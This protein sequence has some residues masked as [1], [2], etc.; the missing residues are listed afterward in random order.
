[1]MILITVGSHNCSRWVS[2]P[3]T[4]AIQNAITVLQNLTYV[5]YNMDYGYN[6]QEPE[7]LK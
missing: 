7:I 2:I 3:E 4:Y 1:M 6:L 5:V